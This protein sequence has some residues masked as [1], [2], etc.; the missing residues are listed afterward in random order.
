[1]SFL[2][3][4]IERK[5]REAEDLPEL[6][7]LVP[8][9]KS[10]HRSL[11]KRKPALIAEVKPKSPSE[12]T[13]MSLTDLPR[14]LR[15][16]NAHAQAISVLCD[17]EAFG[18]GYELLRIVSSMTD[19]PI[20]AKEFIVDPRQIRAARNAGA[21]AILLIAAILTKKQVQELSEEAHALGMCVLLELHDEH[22]IEKIPT[23]PA[24]GL[25]IGINN[26]NLNNLQIDLQTTVSLAPKIKALHPENLL[27]SESGIKTAT[28]VDTLGKIVD[29]FLIG[30]AFLKAADPKATIL[31][32][33][34]RP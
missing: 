24:E 5:K 12:G 3:S 6:S 28:D 14:I 16:Y 15:V 8:A 18:G 11:K 32:L 2:D 30:T 1:M 19:L 23:L 27:V 4:I 17:S 10:L 21:D 7:E 29:G 22:D 20:L 34:P 31:S 9:E 26:R 25:I 33:F 13:L